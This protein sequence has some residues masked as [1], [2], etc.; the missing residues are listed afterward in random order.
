MTKGFGGMPG[1]LGDLNRLMKQAQQLQAQ[2]EKLKEEMADARFEASSGGGLVTATV[3]FQNKLVS[4][5]ISPEAVDT[6]DIEMLEDL[7]LS[8]VHR[9]TEMAQ[10]EIE[11]RT[12]TLTGGLGL[13]TGFM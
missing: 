5:K 8:A 13:P 4:L 1:G 7:I 11:K 2:L 10:E 6:N 9:A 3:D 12:Q